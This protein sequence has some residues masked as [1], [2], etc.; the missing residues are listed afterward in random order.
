M[1]TGY[2]T[3]NR[4]VKKVVEIYKWLDL[5]IHNNSELAG[6]CNACGKCCDFE[7]FGH[8]LFVTTPELAY[9]TENLG[10]KNIKPMKTSRCPYNIKSKC[11]IYEHR[12]ASCRIFCCKGDADFQNC[13][14]E[15]ALKK[16][17]LLCSEFQIPYRYTDLATALKDLVVV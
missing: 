17:K 2:K 1:T 8:K 5:Q 6:V 15:K 11:G 9:I 4:L 3:D 16:F 14:S 12:F 7:S 13:L 10:A